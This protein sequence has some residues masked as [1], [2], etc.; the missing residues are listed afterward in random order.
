MYKT[1]SYLI[2][3]IHL[4]KYILYYYELLFKRWLFKKFALEF[5]FILYLCKK[6]VFL[7]R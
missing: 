4:S 7:D 2:M 3:R 5:L 1:K 6:F